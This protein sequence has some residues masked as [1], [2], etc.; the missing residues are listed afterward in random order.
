M[1]NLVVLRKRA[2]LVFGGSE[3]ESEQW[4]NLA[5]ACRERPLDRKLWASMW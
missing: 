1:S 5:T 2:Y 4:S 3:V